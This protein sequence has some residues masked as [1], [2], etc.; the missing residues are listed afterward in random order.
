MKDDDIEKLKEE[1][2]RLEAAN[3]ECRRQIIKEFDQ[4]VEAIEKSK[5]ILDRLIWAGKLT[6]EDLK[7]AGY[8]G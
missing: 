2:I 5:L 3:K 4:K 6:D 7:M 1:I 8:N